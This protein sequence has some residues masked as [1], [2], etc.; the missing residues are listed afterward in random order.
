VGPDSEITVDVTDTF[1]SGVPAT[2]VSAVVINT[3]GTQGTDYTYLTVYPSGEARPLASNLNFGPGV[4]FPNLVT[5]KVGTDGNVKVYN[6]NGQVHVIFDIVGWYGGPTDGSLF[7]VL[8]PKRILDTRD[9][10]GAPAVKI[11]PDSEITVDVTDTFSSGVPASGVTAVV[12]NT[13]AT[14]GTSLSYLTVY[15]SDATRPLASNLNFGVNQD[16]PNLVIVKVGAADGSVKVY[17]DSG[18]THVIFD[19]V[20]W[21]G[22]SGDLFYPVTPARILDTRFGPQ[23]VPSG[24]V[25]PN[26]EITAD[27]T[28]VGGVPGS[29]SGVIVNT[30]ATQ[31]TVLSYLT[32]YP[33]GAAQ[34]LASNLNFGVNQD[35]PNLVIVGVGTGGNAQVYNK[36]GEVHVIFDV[37]GYFAP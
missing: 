36:N 20:G 11:G 3:T 5:V 22:A 34:P 12:V 10:T 9:G 16:I 27:V 6:K 28:D 4:D 26:A 30:T 13:T 35:I 15:P 7:N 2:D 1:G 14:Q 18:S 19:V 25:Q 31:G 24:K 29:A 32:V 37:V 17:N 21:Y 23:G 8:T 33:S